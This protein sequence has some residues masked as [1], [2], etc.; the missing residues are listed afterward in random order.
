M[1]GK[2]TRITLDCDPELAAF[3]SGTILTA[4]TLEH[5]LEADDDGLRVVTHAVGATDRPNRTGDITGKAADCMN[6]NNPLT[7]RG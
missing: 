7:N 3:V 1:A 4:D 5:L 2:P 6:L